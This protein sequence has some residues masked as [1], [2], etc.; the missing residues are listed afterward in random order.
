[1]V[2]PLIFVEVAFYSISVLVIVG[3]NVGGYYFLNGE[4]KKNENEILNA[5]FAKSLGLDQ[6]L[7]NSPTN[8]IKNLK[9]NKCYCENG[10]GALNCANDDHRHHCAFCN[11]GYHLEGQF[12]EIR[13]KNGDYH[14][15]PNVCFCENGIA[16]S[17]SECLKDKM[18]KCS[19][20][21]TGYKIV[22]SSSA[23]EKDGSD[24]DDEMFI[25]NL[26][27]DIDEQLLFNLEVTTDANSEMTMVAPPIPT[28]G[29]S[30]Q[31][32]RIKQ[33]RIKRPPTKPNIP[34]IQTTTSPKT[35]DSIIQSLFHMGRID[36]QPKTKTIDKNSCIPNSTFPTCNQ[37]DLK[38]Y[39]I[40]R[41]EFLKISC[42]ESKNDNKGL[43]CNLWCTEDNVVIDTW[44]NYYIQ[45][46]ATIICRRKDYSSLDGDLDEQLLFDSEF[47]WVY[48]ENT[49][50][51]AE[52]DRCRC[53]T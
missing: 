35:I 14:C 40:Q 12:S 10:S 49:F 34:K 32:T 18:R 52:F 16:V 8:F 50:G 36:S 7:G 46:E 37:Y 43:V 5:R 45:E 51:K 19:K 22:E 44:G 6:A 42:R 25:T 30:K 1:M 9:N 26:G 4:V 23:C 47:C 15:K 2:C 28:A 24:G 39:L 41:P 13:G 21:N 29:L 3:A 20:C 38:N 48:G 33:S 11:Y 17:D 53:K 27:S 31:H